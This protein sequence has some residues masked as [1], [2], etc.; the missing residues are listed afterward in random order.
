MA[1]DTI[2]KTV[3][4]VGDKEFDTREEAEREEAWQ[5]L[6]ELVYEQVPYFEYKEQV[7]FFLQDHGEEALKLL[8]KIYPQ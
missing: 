6:R 7:E 3:F 5:D 2:V 4:K 8:L 1:V